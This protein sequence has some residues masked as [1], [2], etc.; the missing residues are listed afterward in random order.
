MGE[1][2]WIADLA[3]K[4]HHCILDHL[5]AQGNR[6]YPGYTAS[7]HQHACLIAPASPSHLSANPPVATIEMPIATFANNLSRAMGTDAHLKH[8]DG[9]FLLRCRQGFCAGS[10]YHVGEHPDVLVCSEGLAHA[11]VYQ[12]ALEGLQVSRDAIQPRA[13]I[14]GAPECNTFCCQRGRQV[15]ARRSSFAEF[16][17]TTLNGA[18]HVNSGW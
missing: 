13:Q 10:C 1:Q 17:G 12:Q 18:R 3:P 11:Q 5:L 9:L 8:R 16:W 14:E 4:E 15:A 2:I 6:G 7:Q